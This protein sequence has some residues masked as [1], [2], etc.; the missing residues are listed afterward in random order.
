MKVYTE[1][2]T[3]QV[4]THELRLQGQKGQKSQDDPEGWRVSIL[5]RLGS[6]ALLARSRR[7][8][9]AIGVFQSSPDLVVGRYAIDPMSGI[10]GQSCFNPRP[11]W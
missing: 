3:C 2:I 9:L 5:A 6:R 10:V 7:R 4:V 11:T 8:A 1:D